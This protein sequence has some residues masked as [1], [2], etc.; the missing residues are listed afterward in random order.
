L[1][2]ILCLQSCVIIMVFC[3]EGSCT[4]RD[5]ATDSVRVDTSAIQAQQAAHIQQETQAEQLCVEEGQ[6]MPEA[7]AAERA[8]L[9]EEEERRLREEKEAREQALL[10]E[11]ARLREEEEVRE[12]ARLAE[13]AR[14]REEELLRQEYE[15]ETRRIEVERLHKERQ[16]A[17]NSFCTRYGFSN[18]KEP[19]RAGCTVFGATSTYALHQAAQLGDAKIVEMLLE[20]GAS[21]LQQ[22]SSKRTALQLAQKKNKRG[23][24]DAVL[25]VLRKNGLG[26]A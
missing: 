9:E 21:P 16:A 25:Q 19:R 24:H 14:L 18:L 2:S 23:S 20:E 17:I 7:E 4:P 8:R 11:E 10:A 5:P 1:I 13:E 6:R 22:N 26:G 12:Q 3:C 15:E